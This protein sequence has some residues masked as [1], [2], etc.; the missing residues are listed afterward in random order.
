MQRGTVQSLDGCPFDPFGDLVCFYFSLVSLVRLV[1]EVP[2][3]WYLI[4]DLLLFLVVYG[5]RLLGRL[6]DGIVD[7]V[8]QSI[9]LW[10][11]SVCATWCDFV[12]GGAAAMAA[13]LSWLGCGLDDL[14][15][16]LPGLGPWCLYFCLLVIAGPF[17]SCVIF[18]SL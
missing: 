15:L 9:G 10:S 3:W 4:W 14:C 11:S 7:G 12:R 16:G 5:L 17:E 8:S 13:F 18:V 1:A 6:E 2:F